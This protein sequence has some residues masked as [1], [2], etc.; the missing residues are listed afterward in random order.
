M[1]KEAAAKKTDNNLFAIIENGGKQYKVEQGAE[2]KIDR[3]DFKAKSKITF[4]K[5]LL[6]SDGKSPKVGQPT[7]SGAT[8]TGEIVGNEKDKKIIVFKKKRRH[9]Y[10]RKI[11][12]RQEFTIV[13]IT[14][15]K[16]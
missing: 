6:I 11:G 5:V 15:I 16:G 12:H 14:E 3:T 4:D 7:V 10:R 2:V 8:V 13:K 1:T 9:N